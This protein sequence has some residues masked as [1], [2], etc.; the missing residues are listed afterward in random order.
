MELQLKRTYLPKGTNGELWLRQAQPDSPK[1]ICYTI[2]LPWKN[3]IHRISCI[4]E[5]RYKLSLRYSQR[6]GSHLLVNDVQDRSLILIHPSNDAMAQ[7]KGCIA[8][9]SKLTGEGKGTQSLIA[10]FKLLEQVV[11]VI[12]DEPIWLVVN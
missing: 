8:P 6:H 2:E 4:P 5:G 7:L 12:K 11:P 3:N 9:V 1:L 10:M